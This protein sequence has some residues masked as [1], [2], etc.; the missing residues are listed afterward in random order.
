MKPHAKAEAAAA[1]QATKKPRHA[2]VT[3]PLAD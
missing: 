1:A 2:N 3:G